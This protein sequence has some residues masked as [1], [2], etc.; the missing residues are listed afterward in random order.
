MR[1]H[2]IL[3]ALPRGRANAIS[4]K[5]LAAQCGYPSVRAMQTDL[6][7]LRHNHVI[8]SA[9]AEP[10]GI[11]LPANDEEVHAFIR[12]MDNRGRHTLA[13]LRTAR[14]HLANRPGQTRF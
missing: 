9:S 3:D 2:V 11:F 5:V 1:Q 7:K 4:A 14:Q 13:V 6:H 10:S 8:L 12:E